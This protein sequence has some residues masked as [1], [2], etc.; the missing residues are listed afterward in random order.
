MNAKRI[1]P[2]WG[3]RYVPLILMLALVA[4]NKNKALDLTLPDYDGSPTQRTIDSLARVRA[5]LPFDTDKT[6]SIFANH[7]FKATLDDPQITEVQGLTTANIYNL[8]AFK[9]I[10]A[11]AVDGVYPNT[12]NPS[13]WRQSYLN[14]LSGLFELRTGEIFQIRG[15]DLANMSIV[16]DSIGGWIVI[17][18]LGSPGTAEAGINL[19][20]KYITQTTGATD[21]IIVNAVI[22]TH[23]H[24]DHFGGVTGL[25]KYFPAQGPEVVAPVGFF[26]E[27]VSENVMAGNCMGRRATYM[28]GNLLQKNSLG[29]LGSGLGTQTSTGIAS[30]MKET[31][32]IGTQDNGI[33]KRVAGRTI[34]FW[35]APS[36][37]APAEMIFWFPKFK[38]FCQA[39][40]LNHTLHNLLTLRGAKVRNG[41]LWS[42]YIDKAIDLWGDQ[43]ELSFGSHHWPTMKIEV[44]PGNVFN[45]KEYWE[46][47]RD[48]YRFIHD[49]TLR[50]AN[51]GY[52]M[53]ELADTIR[54]PEKLDKKFHARGYYGTLNHNVKA[55][56]QLY[57]GW[58]D[59]NPAN[60][61]PLPPQE[62]GVAYNKYI[63]RDVMFSAAKA[64]YLADDYR[65][66]AELLNK[67][68]FADDKDSDAREMLARCYDQLGYVAES[69]PWRNFYLTGAK[70]LRDSGGPSG[71]APAPATPDIINNMSNELLLDYLA[72]K[73]DGTQVEA[74]KLDYA[75]DLTIT[76]TAPDA[77][78]KALLIVSNGAVTARMHPLSLNEATG[79][80]V[81]DRANINLL[82][83]G[84]IDMDEL[85]ERSTFGP[86]SSKDDFTKFTR[87]IDTLNFWFNI[88]RN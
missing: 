34:V 12:V 86:G 48:L 18:P 57:F 54:L 74:G 47:Q 50:M 3:M 7:G 35:N 41:L 88:V 76:A 11:T 64:A 31:E 33:P 28:Y 20:N 24:L 63:G 16:K 43:V 73:F 13:L 5:Y 69:G 39:E 45:I 77:T 81:I 15:F 79:S 4:C 85:I 6:D 53:H 78:E 17:D 62:A 8:D 27:A 38:A 59:G 44:S 2:K 29:T 40:D 66:A 68:V 46:E 25:R 80:V 9:F 72:M 67:L 82:M 70:E 32:E 30:I 84:E 10:P 37:E 71:V 49:Q 22:F 19:F 75:F 56:Y 60:L 14:Q 55:Q 87:Y 51:Q 83:L 23:S 36:S 61:N 21:S 1:Y 58:F 52:T 26:D 42:K 65:F